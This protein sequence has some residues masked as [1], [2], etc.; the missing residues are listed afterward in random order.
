VVAVVLKVHQE[1]EHQLVVLVAPVE[2][3]A[4]QT[5]Q[6]VQ[7]Y[8]DKV[9]LVD[10]VEILLLQGAQILVVEVVVQVPLDKM[11]TDLLLLEV[12]VV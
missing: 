11:Q 3:V 12:M 5:K 9:M 8:P 10:L 1:Q 7:E 2:A 4:E 6:V